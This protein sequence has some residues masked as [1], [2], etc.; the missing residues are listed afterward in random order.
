MKVKVKVKTC[1]IL[2]I[3]IMA[4]AEYWLHQYVIW[5]R[6][7]PEFEPERFEISQENAD[8]GWT[9][10]DVLFDLVQQ[11][12]GEWRRLK[13]QEQLHRWAEDAS[14]VWRTS[15]ADF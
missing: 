1:K 15:P 8:L 7:L 12:R 13:I 2:H 3:L 5:K 9:E 11:Y 10:E 14:D 6:L 4:R